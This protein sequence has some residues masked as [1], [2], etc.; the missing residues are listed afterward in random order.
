MSWLTIFAVGPCARIYGRAAQNFGAQI[1]SAD[2]QPGMLR[3]RGIRLE[4]SARI[5]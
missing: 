1:T 5:K 4:Q 3:A 2:H